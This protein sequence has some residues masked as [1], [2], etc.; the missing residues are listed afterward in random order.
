M[1]II[2][3]HSHILPG[4]DDG[5]CDEEESLAMLK[6]AEENGIRE[7]IA[8]PHFHYRRGC[9]APE[10][11]ESSVLKMQSI[12]DDAGI[13]IRLYTGNELYYTHEVLE[14]LKAGQ[15]LTMAESDYVLLEFSPETQKRT[16]QNAVYEFMTEGYYPIIAHMERY[17]AFQMDLEFVDEILR[18]GAYY[19]INAGSLVGQAGWT[20]QRFSRSLMKSGVIQF[21]ATDAHN[22]NK[23]SPR[24]RKAEEWLVKKC[25]E[26]QAVNCLYKNAKMIL[27]NKA[28]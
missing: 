7:I 25:G 2:D 28:I 12:L 26:A 4:L 10:Q 21:A 20:I 23:R 6:I 22:T 27:E 13:R 18:M 11:I 24:I 1:N 19:Q 16:I 5:A 3:I 9:A 14:N 17:Q 8:T 15:A